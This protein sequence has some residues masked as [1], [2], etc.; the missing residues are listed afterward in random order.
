MGIRGFLRRKEYAENNLPLANSVPSGTEIFNTT[1]QVKMRSNGV[2][3]IPLT[4][5]TVYAAVLADSVTGITA[6]TT[7]RE[8]ELP[9]QYIGKNGLIRFFL[10]SENTNNANGK[11]IKTYLNDEATEFK[12]YDST[13]TTTGRT[14]SKNIMSVGSEYNFYV[15]GNSAALGDSSGNNPSYQQLSPVGS[16]KFKVAGRVNN[17]DDT[18]TLTR[19]IIQIFPSF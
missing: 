7:L 12:T 3:W 14:I 1:Y 19:L 5:F 10:A 18:V 8:V 11:E 6:L 9:F 2:R 17:A 4:S 16:L 13:T 15:S